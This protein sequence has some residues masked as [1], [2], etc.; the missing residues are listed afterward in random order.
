MFVC[1]Y[2]L[3]FPVIAWLTYQRS[4]AWC[5]LVIFH[6]LLSYKYTSFFTLIVVCFSSAQV[7]V[8]AS[9]VGMDDVAKDTPSLD[10]PGKFITVGY[11]F[12]SSLIWCSIWPTLLVSSRCQSSHWHWFCFPKCIGDLSNSRS[13]GDVYQMEAKLI[14]WCFHPRRVSSVLFS[15]CLV[16]NYCN[17]T[18]FHTRFNFVYFVLLAESMKFSRIRKPYTYTSASDTTV[19]VRKFLAY[20]SR[21]TLE[22]EIFMRTKISAITVCA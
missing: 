6:R 11:V 10:L 21:Q 16:L 12:L 8:V 13:G 3:W 14:C 17:R 22:Y 19:A 18:N 20:E 15:L 7:A 1:V 9:H 4:S 2:V 5:M